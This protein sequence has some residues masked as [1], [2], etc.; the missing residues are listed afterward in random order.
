MADIN[1]NIAKKMD[2]GLKNKVTAK[3]ID[4]ELDIN[5]FTILSFITQDDRVH[6]NGVTDEELTN[7]R[8]EIS[9]YLQQKQIKE[10]V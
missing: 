10:A 8:D 6:I 2:F 3:V 9:S 4:I 7:M 5:P 1:I